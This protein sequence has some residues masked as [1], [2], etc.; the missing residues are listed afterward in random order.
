MFSV[1]RVRIPSTCVSVSV[2][3]R[4]LAWVFT[5]KVITSHGEGGGQS[6]FEG[7][8]VILVYN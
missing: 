1:I 4:E 2:D 5:A 6:I 8:T 3:T 7:I